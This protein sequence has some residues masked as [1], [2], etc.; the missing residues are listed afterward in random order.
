MVT[1]FSELFE[2]AVEEAGAVTVNV[3]DDWMQGRSAFG[4]LQVAIALRAMRTVVPD[5]ALRT[6][7]VTFMAPVPEGPVRAEAKLLRT[8]KNTAHV[9]ARIV[10]KATILCLVVGVF[11]KA[12]A[13]AVRVMP[14]K[15]EFQATA[16]PVSSAI[17]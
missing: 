9:E 11:G 5:L 10:E 7:Q 8:G 13:S 12:R 4:G 14:T 15:P 16:A 1:A 17:Q 3:T 6:V 2:G